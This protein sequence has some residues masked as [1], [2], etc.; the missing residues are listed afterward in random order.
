MASSPERDP[1]RD[2]RRRNTSTGIAIGAAVIFLILLIDF[3]AQND[4]K[5]TIHFLGFSGR[6]SLALALLVAAVAGA[7]VVLAIGAARIVSGRVAVRRHARQQATTA[8]PVPTPDQP[9]SP[10]RT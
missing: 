3:I 8:A 4:Q 10:D 9:P 6:A 2:A 5:V 1:V 7:L